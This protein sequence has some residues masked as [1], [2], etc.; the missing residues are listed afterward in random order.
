MKQSPVSAYF[1]DKRKKN[2]CLVVS[3]FRQ[4]FPAVT[5]IPTR[6]G[7][8]VTDVLYEVSFVAGT[9][10]VMLV[11]MSGRVGVIALVL[12]IVAAVAAVETNYIDNVM[13]QGHRLMSRPYVDT[14]GKLGT[15]SLIYF[16]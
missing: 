3:H 5:Q 13:D 4:V 6:C 10:P 2:H 7:E 15:D 8:F 14:Q 9:V 16:Q 11:K 1:E 12:S